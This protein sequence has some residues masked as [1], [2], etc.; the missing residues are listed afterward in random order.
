MAGLAGLPMVKKQFVC[1]SAVGGCGKM[2][3]ATRGFCSAAS[4]MR[5]DR[6]IDISAQT[7]GK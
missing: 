4:I 3:V 6:S 7:I 1:H 2:V 5:S